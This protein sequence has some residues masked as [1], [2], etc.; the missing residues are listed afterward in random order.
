[1]PTSGKKPI[2]LSGIATRDRSVTT[3]SDPHADSPRPPPMT[4]PSIRAT[5]CLGNLAIAASRAYSRAQNRAGSS[6]PDRIAERSARAQPALAGALQRH[7][8]HRV[9]VGPP[10]QLRLH[11]GDHGVGERV[12]GARPVEPD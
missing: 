7:R 2:A 6:S 9:V 11:R 4:I 3:R 8:G 12:D 10:L 5:K 1:M